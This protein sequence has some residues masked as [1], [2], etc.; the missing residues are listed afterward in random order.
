MPHT[1]C[2][3][4]ASVKIKLKVYATQH[5]H[6]KCTVPGHWHAIA[7]VLYLFVLALYT[8]YEIGYY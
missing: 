6:R 5:H 4:V 3:D 7:N 1:K 8:K 2:R